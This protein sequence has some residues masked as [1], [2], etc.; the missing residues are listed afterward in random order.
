MNLNELIYLERGPR[1]TLIQWL[2]TRYLLARP[3]HRA[4]CNIAMVFTERKGKHVDTFIWYVV[5]LVQVIFIRI[6][7]DSV[8]NHR[9][10]IVMESRCNS[11]SF[12][13]HIRNSL[14]L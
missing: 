10:Q 14:N 9:V 4:H 2:Q 5:A 1:L 12:R 8:Y 6:E 3:L 7:K 13:A 11:S